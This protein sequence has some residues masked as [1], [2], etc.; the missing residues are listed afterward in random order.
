MKCLKRKPVSQGVG[1]ARWWWEGF[2]RVDE[3]QCY[4]KLPSSKV[5]EIVAWLS[6]SFFPMLSGY[7][8]VLT[9]W[10][11]PLAEWNNS[12][13]LQLLAGYPLMAHQC[14]PLW[15]L[16][17]K[18]GLTWLRIYPYSDWHAD[19]EAQLPWL[20]L[21]YSQG[22][23]QLQYYAQAL[24]RLPCCLIQFFFLPSATQ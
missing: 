1:L 15:V 21:A 6:H 7:C 8:V 2:G 18:E 13:S 10:L 11:D 23:P 3:W 17:S 24:L 22:L 5:Y 14:T 16:P 20:I 4:I 12:F 19:E 9:A